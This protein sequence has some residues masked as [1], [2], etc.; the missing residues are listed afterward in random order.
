LTVALSSTTIAV[1]RKTAE[2]ILA[3]P[4]VNKNKIKVI[5][6]GVAD[7]DFLTREEARRALLGGKIAQIPAKVL[8]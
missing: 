6:N 8:A 7:I 2:Q 5:Y 1:S 4:F 3:F